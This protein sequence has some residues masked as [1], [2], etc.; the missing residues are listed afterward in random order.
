[1]IADRHWTTD[2]MAGA[3]LG[4]AVTALAAYWLNRGRDA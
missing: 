1:V 4:T 3:V 2:I